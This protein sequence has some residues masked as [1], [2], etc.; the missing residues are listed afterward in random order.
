[1]RYE[2]ITDSRFY[3]WVYDNRD[4]LDIEDGA[5]WFGVFIYEPQ[6]VVTPPSPR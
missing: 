6:D 1:M 5:E 3:Q 4:T 2:W